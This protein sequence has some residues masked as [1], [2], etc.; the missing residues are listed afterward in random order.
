[1]FLICCLTE[2][3][4]MAHS[5]LS[6]SQFN[7]VILINKVDSEAAR[8]TVQILIRWIRQKPHDL[9]LHCFLKRMYLGTEGQVLM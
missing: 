7:H 5:L 4:N 1:M 6:S 2:L 9:D 8:K 3:I